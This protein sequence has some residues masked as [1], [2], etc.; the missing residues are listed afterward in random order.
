MKKSLLKDSI[1]QI[2][3][4][5]KRF[6][7][8]LLI[9]LLGVGFFVGMQATSPDMKD[10]IDK[11]FDNQNMMDIEV[12]STLGITEQDI[13]ELKKIDSIENVIP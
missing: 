1:R 10:S 8:T 4:T 7:G 11:Y 5:S 6:L 2:K 9:V 12:I 3:N 13:K